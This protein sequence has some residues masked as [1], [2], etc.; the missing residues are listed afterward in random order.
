MN[1][2]INTN[3]NDISI[4]NSSINSLYSQVETKIDN[5]V[6][7]TGIEKLNSS[8]SN[9]NSS[10]TERIEQLEETV[11]QLQE[12][13]NTLDTSLYSL[14]TSVNDN[15]ILF[16]S[17]FNRVDDTIARLKLESMGI[18]IDTLTEEQERYL[19]SISI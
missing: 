11:Q 12:T 5:T 15:E 14:R 17:L 6:Y 13:I 7:N 19:N 1:N 3:K 9:I 18:Q 4:A 16:T 2:R 8:I 10:F